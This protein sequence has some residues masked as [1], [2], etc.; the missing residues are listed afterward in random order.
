MKKVLLILRDVEA[1]GSNPVTSS[2][3]YKGFRKLETLKLYF[4]LPFFLTVCFD[5]DQFL[6]FFLDFYIKQVY[7]VVK[8]SVISLGWLQNPGPS[9]AGKFPALY[10]FI[11]FQPQDK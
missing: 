9:L 7:K 11:I 2:D 6:I 10:F 5:F 1:V 8:K 4:V 3:V